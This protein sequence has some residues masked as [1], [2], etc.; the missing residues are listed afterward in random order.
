MYSL[1]GACFFQKFFH[2]SQPSSE[3]DCQ[4][5]HE[6]VRQGA[7]H[8]NSRAEIVSSRAEE[9]VSDSDVA[10]STE[11]ILNAGDALVAEGQIAGETEQAGSIA[12]EDTINPTDTAADVPS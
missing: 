7:V 5:R 2:N 6:R 9:L 4:R 1:D 8:R 3:F 10:P 12:G 11:G